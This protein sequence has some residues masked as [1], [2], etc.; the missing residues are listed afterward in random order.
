MF[1]FGNSEPLLLSTTIGDFQKNTVPLL[2]RNR[3]WKA[4]VNVMVIAKVEIRIPR[5]NRSPSYMY[6]G[7]H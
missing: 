3:I 4:L 7:K 6:C 5:R 2:Y 1:F